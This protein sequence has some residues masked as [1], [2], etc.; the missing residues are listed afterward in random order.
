MA[1]TSSSDSESAFEPSEEVHSF[2]PS[3][4]VHA[5]VSLRRGKRRCATNRKINYTEEKHDQFFSDMTGLTS[6]GRT[7]KGGDK[8]PNVKGANRFVF[9]G[10]YYYNYFKSI[11]L[12]MNNKNAI[13]ISLN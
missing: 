5:S 12:I 1:I 11:F 7:R 10:T 8:L 4:E 13:E 6:F 2:E 9:V 3:E